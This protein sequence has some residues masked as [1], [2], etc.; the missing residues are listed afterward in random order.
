[1]SGSLMLLF[2]LQLGF[3]FLNAVFASAEIAVLT[4]NPNKLAQLA[5]EGDKR[6]VRLMALT[7]QPSGFVQFKWA[8]ADKPASSAV[9]TENFR[10]LPSC[11]GASD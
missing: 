4:M 1:M 2:L 6:A 3:I 10:R 9:A 5:S 8:Y 7:D 11:S